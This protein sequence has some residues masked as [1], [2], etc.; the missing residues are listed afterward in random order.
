MASAVAFDGHASLAST[1]EWPANRGRFATAGLVKVERQSLPDDPIGAFTLTLTNVVV[2][3]AIQVESQFAGSSL[4]NGTAASS[5]PVIV[6]PTYAGGGSNDLNNLRIKVRKGSAAPYYKPFETLT[7]AF[8]G[9]QS[10]YCAQI[11]D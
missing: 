11:P 1:F 5:T 4:Y 7:T 2:G 9:S 6:L 10:I 3:S 8:V